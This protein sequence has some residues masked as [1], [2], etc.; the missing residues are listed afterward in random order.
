MAVDDKRKAE[1]VLKNRAVLDQLAAREPAPNPSYMSDP[2]EPESYIPTRDVTSSNP[3]LANP[4]TNARYNDPRIPSPVALSRAAQIEEYRKNPAKYIQDNGEALVNEESLLDKGKTMLGRIFDYRDEADASLFNVDLSAGE[5]VWDGFLRYFTG[6]YDLLNVGMGALV[7]AAPGGVRT[8]EF[9]ELTGNKNIGQV[10]SGEMEPGDAPSVGQIAITS[11]GI[12]AKRI[13]E[14]GARLSDVLL[15]NPATAPFILAGMA[16]DSSK[17]QA[18]D[19]D[20]LNKEQREE[21]FGSGFEQ[22]MS[23][24]TDAGLMFADPLIGAGAVAKVARAGLLGKQ[25]GLAAAVQ[26]RTVSDEAATAV[27]KAAGET[28]SVDQIVDE[29][30]AYG[31]RYQQTVD[32]A[33]G[34]LKLINQDGVVPVEQFYGARV[35]KETPVP[36]TNNPLVPLYHKLAMVDEAD[37][38]VMSVDE[39]EKIYEISGTTERGAIAKMLYDAKSVVEVSTIFESLQ[40]VPAALDRLAKLKPAIADQM[41]AFKRNELVNAALTTEPAK[42]KVVYGTLDKQI[43]N[44][45]QNLDEITEQIS[46]IVPSGSVGDIP[47]DK[48]STYSKLVSQRDILQKTKEQAEY[49]YQIVDGRIKPD[50]LDNF[51]PFYDSKKATAIVNDLATSNDTMNRLLQKELFGEIRHSGVQLPVKSNIYARS[52][53][54]SRLRRGRAAYEF[55][56]EKTSI[57]PKRNLVGIENGKSIIMKSNW[58]APSQFDGVSRFQRSARVWRYAGLET[59]SGYIGLKATQTVNSEREFNAAMNLDLYRGEGF[60]ILDENGDPKFIGGEAKRQEYFRRFYDALNDESQDSLKAILDIEEEIMQDYAKAFNLP[61]KRMA[62][63][64]Q[65]ANR[66]RAATIDLVKQRSFFVNAD[67]TREYVPY[68]ETHLA[69]GVYMQNFREL[70]KLLYHN[71]K[72]DGG[73]S[74]RAK[75]DIP[76]HHAGSAYETFNNIWRPATLLRLSYTQRNVFEGMARAMAYQASLAPLTWP[77]RATTHG[78]RNAINKRVINSRVK[79]ATEKMS[80]TDVGRL[81]NDLDN[82]A[83]E[84][85]Y[86]QSAH[87]FINEAGAAEFHLYK[88]SPG[89]PALREVLTEQEYEAR[90]KAASDKMADIQDQLT[91]KSDEFTASIKGTKFYDWREKELADIRSKMAEH[92]QFMKTTNELMEKRREEDPYANI[93]QEGDNILQSLAQLS[94]ANAVLA[95]KEQ[96]L[97]YRPWEAIGMYRGLAGRQRRIGSGMSMGP[98][99]NYYNDAFADVLE[100]INRNQMSADNTNKMILSLRGDVFNSLF[101]N[102]LVKQYEPISYGTTKLENTQWVKALIFAIEDASSSR[103]V[104]KLVDSDFDVDAVTRWMLSD[105]PE[106]RNFTLQVMK[107]FGTDALDRGTLADKAAELT[108]AELR[109]Y[110][111]TS[112]GRLRPFATE[113]RSVTGDVNYVYD[114]EQVEYF[115]EYTAKSVLDQMQ[116][117]TDFIN[118]LKRR[119]GEKQTGFGK[120]PVAAA[121]GPMGITED[122]VFAIIKGMGAAGENTLNPIIGSEVVRMGTKSVMDTWAS[123]TNSMFRALGT[124]PE[125]AVTRGPFYNMRF[126]AI[127]NQLVEEYWMSQGQTAK[128]IKQQQ[129]AVG[130]MGQK[131]GMTIEHPEFRI[132][133]KELGRIETFAHRRALAD[134]KKWMYTIDRQTYLGKYGEWLFPFISAQQ[135]SVV[136]VG[137][138][139]YKEPWLAPMVADLWRM[140]N[141]LGIEDEEGN[142]KMPMPFK[143]VQNMLQDHPEIPFIGGVLDPDGMITIPKNGLNVWMPETGFGLVPRPSAFVQVTASELMKYNAFPVETPAPLKAVFGDEGGK[144][145]YTY[146]KDWIF[147]EEGTASTK[148][149]SWDKVTPAYIQKIVQSKDE[150]STQYGYIYSQ[151]FAT[152]VMR[153]QARER[154]TYPTENEIAQRTTNQFWFAALGNWGMPTPLTPYPILT[155]PQVE[156]TPVETLQQYYDN[157]VKSD[158]KNASKNMMTQFGDWGLQIANSKVSRNVGGANANAE[159]VTDIRT[160]DPLIR[161]LVPQVGDANLGVLGILINNRGSAVDY[162]D[163][164]YSWQKTATIPGSNRKFREVLSPEQAIAENQ[165]VYFWTAYRA[166]MDQ[167]DARLANAGLKNYQQ[168]AAA[169]YKQAKDVWIAEAM[170]NPEMAGGIVDYQDIGGNRTGA[171]VRVLNAAVTSPLF[172]EQMMKAGKENLL[173]AMGKYVQH[174]STLVTLLQES[175][176]GIDHEDNILLK[177]AWLNIR[178]DLKNSDVRWAEISDMY[179]SNDENP[180]PVGDFID[181]NEPLP[182]ELM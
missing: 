51:S 26:M 15:L 174:R 109:S 124:I 160:F 176:H 7:S 141:R 128:G 107:M 46:Q 70:E 149:L 163:A 136:T 2:Y 115:V 19:F 16:A 76:A 121:S 20:L 67:G 170:N 94:A 118:L 120:T 95:K 56:V 97:L 49:L 180:Q 84:H 164:A 119:T 173:G 43:E 171:A 59:P 57:L 24:I 93:A 74:L 154:D 18:D 27:Y 72:L 88:K 104:Q 5:A 157:L 156:Q 168:A 32:Q 3:L 152:Q 79:K 89:K 8:Y 30:A 45:T 92:E 169:P 139:L 77:V 162:E 179:L 133:S 117:N 17:V 137:R 126:K 83:T 37:K 12:E 113:E 110:K 25:G 22:W 73:Q 9:S 62:E 159:T 108:P 122:E 41:F 98:D 52:V 28:R 125:D 11:V 47:A 85:Y 48:M 101:T 53:A 87:E 36:E 33:G 146:F 105:D 71:Q 78:V 13:R 129:K 34:V 103:V 31:E 142:I 111:A 39:I 167:L 143:W 116:N 96:A 158:P 130:S 55:S 166:F 175:G 132:S 40:G 38:P 106:A 61:E 64:I 69:N 14:G 75:F 134:T 178:Q 114:P 50:Q 161:E 165:R 138:L 131:Q 86:I 60:K 155:R 81:V 150:L 63:F 82:A 58:F 42:L 6:A 181:P 68:L 147:G 144:E 54:A 35:T 65:T 145:F 135:N 23:G 1:S 102:A 80:D 21:A 44:Y 172:I 100:Q 112:G 127:R 123:L 29:M 4:L 90:V 140:P 66:R 99:G 10:L 91:A 153:F 182:A 177:E 148:L 151:Q